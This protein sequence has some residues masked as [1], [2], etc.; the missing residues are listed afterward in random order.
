MVLVVISELVTNAIVHAGSAPE[1]IAVY[2]NGKLLVEVHD[3]VPALSVAPRAADGDSAGGYGLRLVAKL[4][5]RWGW[6]PTNNGK[7]VWAETLC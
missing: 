4:T 2:R 5:Q 7:R 1:P 6:Q 3:H